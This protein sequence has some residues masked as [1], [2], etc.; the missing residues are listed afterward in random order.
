MFGPQRGDHILKAGYV[1]IYIYIHIYIYVYI[2]IYI[3]TY[4]YIYIHMELSSKEGA[5]SRTWPWELHWT[6]RWALVALSNV[7]TVRNLGG[8]GFPE[9][10]LRQRSTDISLQF[11]LFHDFRRGWTSHFWWLRY[12]LVP[13][14][15]R[16]WW[17]LLEI[18]W[19]EKPAMNSFTN[20]AGTSGKLIDWHLL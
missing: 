7:Q 6:F 11:H 12:W 18:S 17:P 1:Y 3:Y 14:Q 4:I 2:Y 13:C 5:R 19:G 10:S 16:S 9:G 20:A 15:I 8:C